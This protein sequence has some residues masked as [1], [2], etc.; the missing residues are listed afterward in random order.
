[1]ADV[2]WIKIIVDV[3][4]DEK[5]RLIETLPDA[6]T[7][8]IVWFKLLTMAGKCNDNGII[9]LTRDIPYNEEMLATLMRRPINTIRLALNEFQKLGMIDIKNNF[10]ALLNWEKH[11]NIEGLK[12]ISE[13]SKVRSQNYRKR[14]NA[15]G[16]YDYYQHY[17]YIFKRD[18]GSC[19]YCN[20]KDDLCID[21]LIPL[22][23][24]G[25]N[26]PDNLVLACKPCNSGKSGKLIEETSIT[27]FNK[28]ICELYEKTKIRLNIT[29]TSRSN[30]ATDKNRVDK[31][32]ED[33]DNN[34]SDESFEIFWDLYQKKVNPKL[35]R[36]LWKKINPELHQS[37]FNHVREYVNSRP[38]K[39]FRKDP[40]RY[41][42]YEMW[43]SE[44]IN[45]Q[46]KNNSFDYDKQLEENKRLFG[47]NQ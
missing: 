4:D 33:I 39:A 5:I 17:D 47:A 40:E 12:K 3:F 6:D 36:N 18:S 13:Q 46:P 30:H 37:I 24:G 29:H 26:E 42:K 23:Q 38:D 16:G 21:H 43:T 34:I 44:I 10:I 41:L 9:Y 15:V 32:R 1:M 20:S 2:K 28:D 22:I 25:D 19:V 35:C 31:N 11:Q 14:L 45:E 27:F 7:I 8:L